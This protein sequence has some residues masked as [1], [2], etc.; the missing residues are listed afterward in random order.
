MRRNFFGSRA[1]S[2]VMWPSLPKGYVRFGAL[3]GSIE[4]L[5]NHPVRALFEGGFIVG[6][7][8]AELRERFCDL[9]EVFRGEESKIDPPTPPAGWAS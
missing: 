2:I 8:V 7:G 5:A 3:A 4:L 1:T 9:L 6:E